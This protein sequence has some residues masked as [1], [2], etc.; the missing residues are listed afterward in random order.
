MG[1]FGPDYVHG[2]HMAGIA[3]FACA[4]TLDD[5]LAAPDAGADAV[6]AQGM[7]AGG[8]RGTFDSDAAGSV[9]VGLFAFLPRLCD[10][11]QVPA[12]QRQL[13]AQYRAGVAPGLDRVNH[14]V[15]QSAAMATDAPAGEV[16]TAMW[17][18]AR[19]LLA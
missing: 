10:R 14:W 2:L 8:H 15:G 5:A 18:D 4:T 9:Q 6:V 1:L 12:Q 19:A 16:I 17:K 11:L 3:W 7:E 13:V